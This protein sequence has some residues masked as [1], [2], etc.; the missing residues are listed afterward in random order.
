MSYGRPISPPRAM[1]ETCPMFRYLTVRLDQSSTSCD[2]ALR[3]G[4]WALY[5]SMGSAGYP[6]FTPSEVQSHIA[7]VRLLTGCAHA[8]LLSAFS[9][10]VKL[11]MPKVIRR[12][13]ILCR[14]RTW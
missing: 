6:M 7:K 13:T 2:D 10:S 14:R 9:T 5:G 8:Y 11:S 12:E 3:Q 4:L 1:I